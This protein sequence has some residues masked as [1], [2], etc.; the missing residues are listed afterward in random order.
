MKETNRIDT[1]MKNGRNNERLEMQVERNER[2]N[3]GEKE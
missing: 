2:N 1:K 3:E